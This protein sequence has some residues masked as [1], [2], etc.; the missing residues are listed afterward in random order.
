MSS[1]KYRCVSTDKWEKQYT[2]QNK[3]SK[4][5]IIKRHIHVRANIE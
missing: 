2:A 3:V 1:N 4:Q 5:I